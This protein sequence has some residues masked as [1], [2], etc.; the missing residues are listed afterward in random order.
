MKI[1]SGRKFVGLQYKDLHLYYQK[2]LPVLCCMNLAL[3]IHVE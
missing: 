3:S 2:F 1:N